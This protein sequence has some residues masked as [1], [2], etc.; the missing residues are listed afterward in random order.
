M[1]DQTDPIRQV[2]VLS[3]GT[4]DIHP[5][6]A[7]R[8]PTPVYWWAL[9]SRRWLTD[10]PINV[11]VV[12]HA[13]GLVVFDTGQDRASITDPDY[14]PAGPVGLFYRRLAR[15]AIGPDETLSVQLERLGY[16]AE[17]VAIAVLS[18]LHQDHIGGLGELRNARVVVTDDEYGLL[19]SPADEARGVLSRHIDLPGLRW[20][21]VR[22]DPLDDPDIAP[23]TH[24]YDLMGDRSM[25]LLPTPGHTP[26][27]LSMLVRR[28]GHDPLLMVGDLTYDAA[29]M[30]HDRALSGVGSR[31]QL[32][33]STRRVLDLKRRHPDLRILGA[34]DPGAAATLHAPAR[35]PAVGVD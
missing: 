13:D 11:F 33:E 12:D 26:G 30:E 10:R 4:V 28:P 22:F 20:D 21:R 6:H 14:F 2:Q 19:N 27:S 15:F 17:E 16:A 32:R 9:T 29:A 5:Q 31:R 8:G 25:V 1:S 34:H 3:T 18:H 23:F 7:Y 35:S 24:G